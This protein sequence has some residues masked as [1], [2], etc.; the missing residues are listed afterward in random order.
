M[1]SGLTSYYQAYH[2]AKR[3]L[4]PGSYLSGDAWIDRDRDRMLYTEGW[5][6]FSLLSFKSLPPWIHLKNT[7]HCLGL[8]PGKIG[9]VT[10][11]GAYLL[12]RDHQ[13]VG[14]GGRGRV[15]VLERKFPE[16]GN[17]G[18][19]RTIV[20]PNT[21]SKNCKEQASRWCCTL[22]TEAPDPQPA[23]CNAQTLRI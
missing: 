6:S 11:N 16:R 21:G 14:A 20:K 1:E 5:F 2:A 10:G 23:W 22:R 8:M 4:L 7:E 19:S 18:C 12:V 15:E 3:C 9:K 17:P 13:A